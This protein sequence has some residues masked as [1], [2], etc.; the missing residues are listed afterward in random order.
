[1]HEDLGRDPSRSAYRRWPQV[2]AVYRA[3]RYISRR[4]W[5]NELRSFLAVAGGDRE[6]LATQAPPGSDGASRPPAAIVWA[7]SGPRTD[8]T[9][10]V[11]SG[12]SQRPGSSIGTLRPAER[13]ALLRPVVG[14]RERRTPPDRRSDQRGRGCI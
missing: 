2:R 6:Q 10:R 7:T 11:R 13:A 4:I 1:M 8:V 3:D 12:S 5:P 14:T 9:A